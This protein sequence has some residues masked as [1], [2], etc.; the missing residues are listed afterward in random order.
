MARERTP[1][2][3]ELEERA[4]IIAEGEGCTRWLAQLTAARQAGY[5]SWSEAILKTSA[6][7]K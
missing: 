7:R 5:E 4:A 2:R 1:E 6:P 3:E